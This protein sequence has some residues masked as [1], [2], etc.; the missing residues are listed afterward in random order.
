MKKFALALALGSLLSAPAVAQKVILDFEGGKFP[1]RMG[2]CP[3][4]KAEPFNPF[5]NPFTTME[6]VERGEGVLPAGETTVWTTASSTYGYS[7]LV[8][9]SKD[10]KEW[11]EATDFPKKIVLGEK[12]ILRVKQIKIIPPDNAAIA[13]YRGGK[14]L[15][16]LM[17]PRAIENP[18]DFTGKEEFR[19]TAMFIAKYGNRTVARNLARFAIGNM[20]KLPF[21]N[22]RNNQQIS[23]TFL[24]QKDGKV[25]PAQAKGSE[26]ELTDAIEVGIQNCRKGTTFDAQVKKAED[27][28]KK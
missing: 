22:A 17:F 20:D 2:H 21:G 14:I 1:M 7:V 11:S 13:P 9:Y 25:F 28:L 6:F 23:V 4:F 8:Q 10:G 27:L 3:A 24:V 26:E 16:S 19:S 15:V 5:M 18:P 12:D